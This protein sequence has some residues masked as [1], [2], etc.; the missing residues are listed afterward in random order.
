MGDF[1]KRGSSQKLQDIAKEVSRLKGESLQIANALSGRPSQHK[2]FE[3][4]TVISNDN[5]D[6]IK[7]PVTKTIATLT[8]TDDNTVTWKI[9]NGTLIV[10]LQANK[11]ATFL[12]LDA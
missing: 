7:Q 12:L 5:G 8:S 9:L 2:F 10:D 3:T 1:L 11:T 6:V 4:V